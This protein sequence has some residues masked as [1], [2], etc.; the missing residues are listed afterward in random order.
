MHVTANVKAQVVA[1]L[2][3]SIAKC[4]AHYGRT[5]KMPTIL[6]TKRGTTAGTANYRKY[7]VNFNPVLLM[8][9]LE[10]F[11]ARTV[12]HEMAHLVDHALH[13]QNF[14]SSFTI[15]QSGRYKR[16]KRDVH[17]ATFK[18]IMHVMGAD[19]SRCHSYDTSNARVKQKTLHEWVCN[20]CGA[21]MTLGPKRNKKMMQA[22][23]RGAYRPRGAGCQWTHTYRYVGIE[24]P[25]PVALAANAPARTEPPKSKNVSKLDKC[26]E[27]YN[28]T[29][30][31][32]WN[33][34]QFIAGAGCTTAGAATYYAKIKK[35]G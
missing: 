3:S 7:E 18:A 12:P 9:N 24:R 35:G 23:V 17:G 19:G 1:K 30:S 20:D 6:Y 25:E 4:E 13:P 34:N 14:E 32:Q 10:D 33:I 11:I 31:R 2:K 16:T 8:E 21:T 15:T 27:L 5:F 29:E 26:R 22:G 28:R